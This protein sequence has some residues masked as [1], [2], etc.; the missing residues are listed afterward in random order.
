MTNSN[1][2]ELDTDE[3]ILSFLKEHCSFEDNRVY[4]LMTMARPRENNCI[5]HNNI[6]IFREI[7][8]SQDKIDTKYSK[9]KSISDNYN[10]KE[11]IDSLTFRFY[12][13]VNA[14]DIEKSFYLY[15]KRLLKYQYNLNNGHEESYDKIKRLDKEWKST[16]QQKGNK[17]DNY[18][19]IDIDDES[20][21]KF[22]SISKELEDRTNILKRVTTPNG[23]HIITDPFDYTDWDMHDEKEYIEVKTDDLIFISMNNS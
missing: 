20:I 4:I 14:R 16:L 19:V 3:D 18:F 22:E 10:P 9:L 23:F 12:L 6:P 8:T 2:I 13:T 11:D 1:L 17:I 15:Q 7:I 21:S 5:T